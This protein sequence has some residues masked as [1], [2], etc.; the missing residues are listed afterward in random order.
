M[1][2]KFTA[3]CNVQIKKLTTIIKQKQ[4]DQIKLLLLAVLKKNVKNY[5]V[6]KEY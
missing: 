1:M 5:Q 2:K 4:H 6:Q 3:F